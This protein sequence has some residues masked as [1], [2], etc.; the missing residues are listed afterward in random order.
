MMEEDRSD[1]SHSEFRALPDDLE[2]YTQVVKTGL[3]I[4]HN[5]V[6]KFQINTDGEQSNLD[7]LCVSP[8]VCW[9]IWVKCGK[10]T[11]D[12]WRYHKFSKPVLEN[13]YHNIGSQGV[14]ND[15]IVDNP[16][17]KLSKLL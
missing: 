11:E 3:F 1:Y 2:L 13:V 7:P 12:I 9:S 17:E 8:R 5:Y 4:S 6:F 14:I 15:G 16:I 10:R